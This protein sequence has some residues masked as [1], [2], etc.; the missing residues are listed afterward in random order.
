MMASSGNRSSVKSTRPTGVAGA[1]VQ[2]ST[3]P[4][5]SVLTTLVVIGGLVAAVLAFV[6]FRAGDQGGGDTSAAPVV[7]GDLHAVAVIDG[8]RFV[9]GH[10]G[11][12]YSDV[13]GTW[14]AIPTLEGKD[15]MAWAT[16]PGA[17][18]VGGHEGL[19]SSIDGGM[20]FVAAGQGLPISDVHALGSTGETVYLASPQAGLFV[21]SDAGKTFTHRSDV[22]AS[23]M[24]SMVVDP[25]DEAHVLAPDM[26]NGVVETSDG[27]VTWR[28]LGGPPGVMSVAVD[29]EQPSRIFA[30]GMNG[31]ALTTDGGKTWAA[32]QV[33]DGTA[34]IA[35]DDQGRLVAAALA[36]EQAE[37]SLSSDE[38]KT[39]N[40][41]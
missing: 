38:G 3:T 24:G 20:S 14:M 1:R 35:F 33:P 9:S 18:L 27:G 30:S 15:G 8:R 5:R 2:A 4:R 32:I 23:F 29:P 28:S 22:G 11:A 39:W 16:V 40:R 7:G 34:A 37:V 6:V 41:V 19:Y 25:D 13:D 31:A 12:G 10:S 26:T 21:S 36:G 17:I